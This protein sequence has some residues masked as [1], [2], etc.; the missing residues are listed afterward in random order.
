MTIPSRHHHFALV[1]ALKAL[2]SQLI[3][4]H[5]LAFYG[6]MSDVVHPYAPGLIDWFYDYARL[7]VQAFLVMGGFLAARSLAP[8][9]VPAVTELGAVIRLVWRR[10]LRL[11]PPYL[12]AL[13]LAIVSAAMARWLVDDPAIPLA[14]SLVQVGAH[15]LLLQDLVKVEALSAGVWYVAIDL[16]LYA[17]LALMLWLV[18]PLAARHAVAVP[19]L[20]FLLCAGLVLASLFWFNRNPALDGWAPYF[21][22]AFGLGVL[23]QWISGRPGRGGWG[24]LLAVVVLV[25]LLVEWRSRILVAGLTAVLLAWGTG[26]R[27]PGWLRSRLVGFLGRISYSL[28]LA[29]YPVCLAVGALVHYYWPG[30]LAANSIG[31]VVAWG[32]SLA[33]G[34]VLYRSVEMRALRAA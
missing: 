3:V 24:L 19:W 20:T 10:Y 18:R 2:A 21:F 31:M 9:M 25:A 27:P 33:A 1:D 30:D 32:L 23:A 28:F 16:Q 13:A 5:H 14:P 15:I 7:G 34:S 12:V 29:H 11:A 26:H 4:W 22:G 8:G 6:P 17:L